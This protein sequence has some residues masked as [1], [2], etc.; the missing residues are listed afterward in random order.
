MPIQG[1][2]ELAKELAAIRKSGGKPVYLVHGSEQYLIRTAADAL[3]KA[4]AEHSGAEIVRVDAAGQAPEAVLEPV[5]SMS[6]FASAHVAV[7]RNFAPLLTGDAADRLLALLDAGLGPGSALVFLATGDGPADK[8]DRRV[9]GYKGLAGRGVVLELNQQSPGDLVH[10]MTEKASDE[11]KKLDADAARLLL[12][13][14]GPDMGVL[15]AELDKALLFCLDRDRIR[16]KD[17]EKLVGKTREE[18]VWDVGEAIV[19]GDGSRA[20]EMLRD[21][22][23]HGTHPLVVLT[24]LVRQARHLLQARLVWEEA[25]RPP[26]RDYRSFQSRVAST[27]ENGLFGKGPDDVTAI[28]PFATFKRF[29]VARD[30]DVAALREMLGRIRRTEVMIKTGGAED[31]EKAMEELVLELAAGARRAA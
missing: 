21:L 15:R 5:V 3:A 23:A 6:L 1:A 2:Q 18:M 28:K 8:I 24:L 25:G 7:V 27:Y 31:A 13:R 19:R 14:A 22:A 10:W 30:R 16:A 12:D 17:L 11:G 20:R 26:F 9:R 29:E 4:L